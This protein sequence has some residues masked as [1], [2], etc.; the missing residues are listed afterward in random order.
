MYVCIDVYLWC[1]CVFECGGCGVGPPW[2]CTDIDKI[3]QLLRK[4][5]ALVCV[6]TRVPYKCVYGVCG[7]GG[8]GG[9]V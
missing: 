4:L 1:V 7:G 2:Y 9:E 8:G 3:L 5:V 6:C